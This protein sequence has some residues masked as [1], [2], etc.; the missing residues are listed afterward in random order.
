MIM[1]AEQFETL[2]ALYERTQ[3]ENR[4]LTQLSQA[5]QTVDK[6]DGLVA[7]NTRAWLRC[8]DGWATEGEIDD[9]FMLSLAKHTST[10]D[11]LEE[12][13]RWC[14]TERTVGTWAALKAKIL[15]HFLSACENLKLQ[16]LLEKATQR[17]GETVSTYIRRFKAEAQRAYVSTRAESEEF[18]VVSSF[19]RGLSDRRFAERVFRKGKTATLT[20]VTDTALELE[21]VQEK[22]DQVLHVTEPEPMEVDAV[23][24]EATAPSVST[25]QR[26]VEHLTAQLA[27]AERQNRQGSRPRQVQ[28][29]SRAGDR[30]NSNPQAS[31][32]R[33]VN[34]TFATPKTR[35]TRSD[36][37]WTK[38]GKPI[39]NNCHKV[40][41]LYRECH[42]RRQHA[43]PAGSGASKQLKQSE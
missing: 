23:Q 8:M 15:E 35:R 26:Q 6:C 18:R 7:E 10:G 13:R 12:I 39:C 24:A 38:E 41:H 34:R 28:Q 37:K 5:A 21:A 14:N 17:N 36:H 9:A 3:V 20:E 42:D 16:A 32:K 22:M 19:L 40:G 29:P 30:T 27:K 4:H 43:W 25:L 2:G 33:G 1:T 31:G 11:L